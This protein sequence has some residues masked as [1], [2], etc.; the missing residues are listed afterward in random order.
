M[1]KKSVKSIENE[2][3]E[4]ATEQQQPATAPVMDATQPVN[5][6]A[7]VNDTKGD[8]KED[9]TSAPAGD[10]KEDTKDNGEPKERKERAK[11]NPSALP[12]R[13]IVEKALSPYLPIIKKELGE[14][15]DA[16]Q[17]AKAQLLGAGYDIVNAL[18]DCVQKKIYRL[19][20]A[21]IYELRALPSLEQHPRRSTKRAS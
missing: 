15:E 6:S 4:N 11:M 17:L 3:I 7:P 5:E 12:V 9:T 20:K 21:F 18:V 19:C 1:A 14:R 16:E 8:T 13:E 2:K 10:T